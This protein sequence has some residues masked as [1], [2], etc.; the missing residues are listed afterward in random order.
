MGRS[1][2]G[3]RGY[4]VKTINVYALAVRECNSWIIRFAPFYTEK[5]GNAPGQL[6]WRAIR[7]SD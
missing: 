7:I 1:F 4:G 6:E 5:A 2:Q 3:M